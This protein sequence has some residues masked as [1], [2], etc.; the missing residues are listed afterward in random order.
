MKMLS[1]EPELDSTNSVLCEQMRL[2]TVFSSGCEI[3]EQEYHL[4]IRSYSN[5]VNQQVKFFRFVDASY[6]FLCYFG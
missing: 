2:K 5:L 1:V 3:E 4:L 6:L